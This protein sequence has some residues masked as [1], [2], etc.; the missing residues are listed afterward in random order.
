MQNMGLREMLLKKEQELEKLVHIAEKHIDS[1]LSG[2]LHISMIK[3]KP[4]YYHC[5]LD[6]DGNKQLKYL[7]A[8]KEG[9]KIMELAQHSYNEAFLKTAIDQLKAVRRA[10]NRIDEDALANVFSLLHNERKKLI[11]P[12]EPDEEMFVKLWEQDEYQPGYF[13]DQTPLIYSN[14][15]DRVRSK[16]EKIIAD[17]YYERGIPY[18]YEKPLLLRKHSQTITVR[19]DFTTLNKRT[20]IQRYHEHFGKM[21][22][23]QYARKALEKIKLY[24]N[25]GIFIG[26]QL[27]LTFEASEQPL[28]KREIELLIDKYLI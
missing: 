28:D 11:T 24:E 12:F 13:S 27:I 16:S 5:Y 23:P 8:V 9:P 25:N 26:D 4:R 15:G 14:R 18:K 2:T 6:K 20:R 3:G 21:D 10:L 17:K 22:D 7:S 19:P 1:P